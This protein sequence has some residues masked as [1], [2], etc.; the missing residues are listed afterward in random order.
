MTSYKR[1]NKLWTIQKLVSFK[2]YFMMNKF[3]FRIFTN[4]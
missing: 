4:I 3:S 1:K 2:N